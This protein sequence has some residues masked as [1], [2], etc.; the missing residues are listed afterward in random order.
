[1]ASVRPWCRA[2]IVGPFGDELGCWVLSGRGRPDLAVVDAI[3]H[4]ALIAKR[5]GN[6][7]VLEDVSR[8]LR[9]LVELAGL[10]IEMQW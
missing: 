3:A 4:L 8:E 10:N 5:V 9:A 7:L 1:M 2:T 6:V